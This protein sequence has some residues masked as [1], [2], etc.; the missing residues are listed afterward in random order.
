MSHSIEISDDEDSF[1]LSQL[2]G[3]Q[4]DSSD[5]ET[6]LLSSDKESIGKSSDTVNYF[7]SDDEEELPEV[8]INNKRRNVIKSLFP[9]AS[10]QVE[11][12]D[13]NVKVEA[14]TSRTLP[15]KP[16]DPGFDKMIGGVTVNL[17]VDPY[18][19]Q[20]ALMFKVSVNNMVFYIQ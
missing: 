1:S 9:N 5:N 6:I 19:C 15:S 11:Q 14:S 4:K 3:P 20:V 10:K 17:P 12:I 8:S 7:T 16:K 2:P 13:N 18:G